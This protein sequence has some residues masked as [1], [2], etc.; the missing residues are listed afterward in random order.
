M[1]DGKRDQR[2][3]SSS[4][5]LSVKTEKLSK[6]SYMLVFR[7]RMFGKR[8]TC[9]GGRTIMQSQQAFGKPN[10]SVLGKYTETITENA[11]GIFKGKNKNAS[12]S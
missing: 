7:V 4:Q 5:G 11:K 2:D 6:N 12:E 9:G 8:L 3:R 10:D 1:K